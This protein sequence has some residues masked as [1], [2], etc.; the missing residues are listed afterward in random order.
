MIVYK[1]TDASRQ[2]R[3]SFQYEIGIP[4]Y[5]T[6]TGTRLC[7]ADVLHA[8][9]TPEQAAFMCP[10]HCPSGQRTLW[11]AE[12]PEIVAHDGTKVG[13]KSLTLL[14]PATL[15]SLTTEQRIQV[16]IA[17]AW[18]CTA[19]SWRA[20]ALA[21]LRNVDRSY[22]AAAT[23][24]ADAY[25]AYAAATAAADASDLND[26]LRVVLAETCAETAARLEAL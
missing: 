19:R 12:V 20:W 15:P 18:P 22:T 25:A 7:S 1:L 26:V 21:W 11:E 14:R 5:A 10:V 23:A 16:A 6:G 8:Y 9:E 4:A 17:S 3:H 13:V 2:T 24:V